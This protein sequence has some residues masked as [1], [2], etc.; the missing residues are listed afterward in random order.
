MTRPPASPGQRAG[1]VET[2]ALL[3]DLE[4]LEANLRTMARAS[5]RHGVALRPHAKAHKCSAIARM[6][7]ALGAVGVCCQKVS[8]AEAMVA[9]GIGDVYV[10]NQVVAAPK[11]ERL[12]RLAVRARVSLAVDSVAGIEAAAAAAATVGSLLNV[13][14]E[15]DLGEARAGV[16]PGEA[17]MTLARR[18][19][20][21][22]GL[23][24]G[25]LHAYR[26]L[27]QHEPDPLA[28]RRLVADAVAA[29]RVTQHCL[30]RAGLGCLTV[31]GGGT[32]SY[33]LEAESSV[34]TEIQPGTY[35]LLDARYEDRLATESP[36]ADR[37]VRA[38]TIASTITSVTGSG[39]ALA[40][41]GSKAVETG[42]AGFPR[43]VSHAGV[44]FWRAD[45]EHGRLQWAEGTRGP[46]LGELV[47]LLPANVD[48]TV[49]L[50]DWLVGTRDGVVE[51]VWP[52]DARGP[53]L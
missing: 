3:V 49:N 23:R 20:A 39:R 27:A 48:P 47:R 31:T 50:H 22:E 1:E 28:R 51:T 17:A 33:L 4:I 9:G 11:L 37:F 29:V 46:R 42:T 26:S 35:A 2:P 15:I 40:D 30:T 38:L 7:A 12:A 44:S 25:G 43:V 18:I 24:F 13:L 21:A 52:I 32:G 45:D 41:A 14:V 10:S 8:E 16:P 34:F 19:A 36:T 53:G 6:Q 5:R